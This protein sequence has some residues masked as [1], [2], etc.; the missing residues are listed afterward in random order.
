MTE[1]TLLFRSPPETVEVVHAALESLWDE[2][3][4]IDEM[5]RMMFETALIEL[6]ANV[7]QHGSSSTTIICRLEIVADDLRLRAELVDTADPPGIDTGPREM[8]D[9]FAESGRGI[10]FIQALVDAFDYERA[11]G[12]NVW[13]LSKDRSTGES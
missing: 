1:R 3:P 11:E 5:D 7:I 8:P 12:R 4:D 2:R 13:T 9:E 10:A 6:T